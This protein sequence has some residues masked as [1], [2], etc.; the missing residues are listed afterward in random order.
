M[1]ENKNVRLSFEA[2]NKLRRLKFDLQ[3]GTYTEVFEMLLNKNPEKINLDEQMKSKTPDDTDKADDLKKDDKTIVIN[4][5]VHD[6]LTNLKIEYM[7]DSG[8]TSRGKGAVSISDVVITLIKNYE[9][10][11]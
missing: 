11:Q 5:D 1:S 7:M 8:L 3:L 4:K 2:W 9:R 10:A 6:K